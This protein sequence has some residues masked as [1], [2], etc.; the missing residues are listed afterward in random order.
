MDKV[1]GLSKGTQLL[2]ASAI[3]RF[4]D[5]FLRWQE[6][7]AGPFCAGQNGWHGFWGIVLGLLT[8]AV[9]AWVVLRVVQPQLLENVPV[10]EGTLALGLGALIL[11]CAVI[12]NL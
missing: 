2:G 11:V 6:A 3:L 5:L 12:K 9:I 7:C 1:Q 4:S 10:P 8:I